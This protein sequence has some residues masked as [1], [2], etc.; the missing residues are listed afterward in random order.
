MAALSGAPSSND[1]LV[2]GLS[3]AAMPPPVEPLPAELPPVE[4]LRSVLPSVPGAGVDVGVEVGVGVPVTVAY[5]F[6]LSLLSLK[7]YSKA[8]PEVA[9]N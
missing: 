2:C 9:C 7:R 6:L 5:R 1:Y 3:R 8:E 4:P